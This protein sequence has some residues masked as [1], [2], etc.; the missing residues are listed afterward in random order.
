MFV[1]LCAKLVIY[2]Q[3]NAHFLFFFCSSDKSLFPSL[4]TWFFH[5][6]ENRQCSFFHFSCPIIMDITHQLLLASGRKPLSHLP[7]SDVGEKF[8]S[9]PDGL[10]VRQGTDWSSDRART[11]S[12]T[13]DGLSLPKSFLKNEECYRSALPTLGATLP[14]TVKNEEWRNLSAVSAISA[15]DDSWV[16]QKSRKTQK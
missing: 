1:D 8:S 9:V 13:E 6:N 7:L 3:S 11:M 14:R 5:F 2:F 10:S 4:R 16:T 12:P 15:W